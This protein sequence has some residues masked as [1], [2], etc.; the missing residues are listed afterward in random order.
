MDKLR[1]F[2]QS[3]ADRIDAL[4]LRERVLVF[5]ATVAV[6]F[7]I[8]NAVLL[9]PLLAR[10]K[11]MSASLQQRQGEVTLIE[12]QIQGVLQRR[13]DD[14]NAAGRA[15]QQD[16]ETRLAG[17]DRQLLERQGR[18]VPPDRVVKLLESMLRD[19]RRLQVVSLRSIPP[20]VL[21]S[22]PG[23][24]AAAPAATAAADRGLYRHGIEVSLRG[25]Y[26]DLVAYVA[27]LEAYKDRFYLGASAMS[28][29][30]VDATLNLSLY[31]ISLSSKWVTF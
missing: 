10:Q 30:G 18:L 4:S 8:Y 16:L 5:L 7:L 31:T 3:Y 2:L 29:N 25:S 27:A 15:A 23:T 11:T 12:Q 24:T 9:E 19:N 17:L 28:A 22:A 20:V 1:L 21:G 6:L 14:P 13:G 26:P